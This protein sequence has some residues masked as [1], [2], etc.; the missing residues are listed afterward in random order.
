[1]LNENLVIGADK[2]GNVFGLLY[3]KGNNICIKYS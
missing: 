1:M 2:C 3:D